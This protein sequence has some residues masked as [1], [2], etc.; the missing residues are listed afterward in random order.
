MYSDDSSSF[1][2]SDHPSLPEA[3]PMKQMEGST[4]GICALFRIEKEGK[5]RVLKCLETRYRG[6]LAYEALLRKE[7]EIG[8]SLSN[9]YICE[10]YSFLE[11]PGLGRC[12][13]MEWIDGIP[14]EEYLKTTF[15]TDEQKLRLLNQL[16]DAVSYFHSKQ[17]VHKDLK[18]SNLLVTHNGANIKIIDFG[19]ADNDSYSIL[20]LSAGTEKYAAPE[21]IAGGAV[22]N[23]ADIWSLGKILLLFGKRWRRAARK[24]LCEDPAA[25]YGSVEELRRAVVKPRPWQNWIPAVILLLAALLF[26][27]LLRPANRTALE[28]TPAVEVPA[29]VVQEELRQA[30][31]APV[32]VPAPASPVN[33]ARQTVRKTPDEAPS[34]TET[35]NTVASEV[36]RI[37]KEAAGLFKQ[38]TN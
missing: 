23:R 38:K 29:A 2:T 25:R 4:N 14:L 3:L 22:D 8:Y 35:E 10:V 30:N 36:D 6:L 17:V 16:F 1:F 21:L 37:V 18:P 27:L 31:P 34:A 24:C 26:F 32:P 7:Y 13:E 11:Y 5:R 15:P 33:P 20:K 12:I 28:M 9:P 19:F